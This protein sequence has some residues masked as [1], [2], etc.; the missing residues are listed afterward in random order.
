MRCPISYNGCKR[1]FTLIE[2]LVAMMILAISLVVI[3]QLFSAGLK[4]SGLSDNY[5]RAIFH[6]RE[7]MEE[8]LIHDEFNCG[9]LEGDF[10]DGFI[11]RAEIVCPDD[12]EEEEAVPPEELITIRVGVSWKE[13]GRR[14]SF[15]ISTI[16]VGKLILED[17]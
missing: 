11:W 8:L 13:W 6:A 1:G 17:T 4:S 9:F 15:E 3:L 2:I 5:T 16:K 7:K 12:G 10:G 14:K